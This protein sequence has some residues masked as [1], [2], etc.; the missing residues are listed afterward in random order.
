MIG[1][2]APR[3]V[4]SKLAIGVGL[5]WSLVA[6][7]GPVE[8][9]DAAA[10]DHLQQAVGE[11]SNLVNSGITHTAYCNSSNQCSVVFYNNI[12]NTGSASTSNGF[13]V[14]MKGW[15]ASSSISSCTG[16]W[17]AINTTTSLSAG[18]CRTITIY[19][20]GYVG[21]KVS[22]GTTLSVT[23]YADVHCNINETSESDN[24]RTA[25]IRVGY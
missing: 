20:P 13:V 4:S 22:K 3:V 15:T 9:P 25:S 16:N 21:S 24:S 8:E 17:K 7:C 18:S 10:V 1:R 6:A 12:C 23:G 5:V 14:G 2:S 19:G 11:G